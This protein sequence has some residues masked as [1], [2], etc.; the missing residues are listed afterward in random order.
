MNKLPYLPTKN[1]TIFFAII[2]IIA[3]FILALAPIIIKTEYIYWVIALYILLFIQWATINDC[4]FAVAEKKMENSNYK[5]GELPCFTYALAMI[6]H[7][8]DKKYIDIRLL[9][10]TATQ[11]AIIVSISIAIFIYPIKYVKKLNNQTKIILLYALVFTTAS[12][13]QNIH[14]IKECEDIANRNT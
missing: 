13:F 1:K 14:K 9:N 6:A 3:I 7:T 4:I 8:F 12:K 10:Y 5:Y 11:T 2:H